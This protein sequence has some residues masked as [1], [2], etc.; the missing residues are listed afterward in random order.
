MDQRARD[1]LVRRLTGAS[2]DVVA[3]A[4]EQGVANMRG[5]IDAQAA[6]HAQ[7][8]ATLTL[9]LAGMGGSLA[10]A[11]Q[12]FD[13]GPTPLASGAAALC[14]YL[15]LLGALTVARCVN[16]QPAPTL[17]NEPSNLVEPGTALQQLRAGELVNLQERI[18]Q[19]IEL[20]ARKARWLN[21]VRLAAL[22]SPLIFVLGAVAL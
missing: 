6:L 8:S 9:L 11:V 7:A 10:Y 18:E 22:A 13:A 19:Q 15:A 1:E 16:V 5:R 4:W 2:P 3:W 17:H 12:I 14:A 20:S 21:G